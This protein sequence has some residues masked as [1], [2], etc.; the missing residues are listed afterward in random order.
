MVG[1]DCR[2][3]RDTPITLKATQQFRCSWD[4][5]HFPW[6]YRKAAQEKKP[7]RGVFGKAT[8]PSVMPRSIN[9]FALITRVSRI[10]SVKH[11]SFTRF[12]IPRSDWNR[13]I[14][15]VNH[16]SRYRYSS[17]TLQTGFKTKSHVFSIQSRRNLWKRN[18]RNRN[19][20][21]RS[22]QTL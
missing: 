13:T 17:K 22:D 19:Q 4:R 1:F 20:P 18:W 16:W 5:T 3:N 15:R 2:A 21:Q 14:A 12:L 8:L 9:G 10:L 11:Q 6:T 7:Q